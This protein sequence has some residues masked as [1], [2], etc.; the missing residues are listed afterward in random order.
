MMMLFLIF[1]VFFLFFYRQKR[2]LVTSAVLMFASGIL[3]LALI[4]CGMSFCPVSG[5][6]TAIKY[7][8]SGDSRHQNPSLI[9]YLDSQSEPLKYTAKK[10]K[11]RI[12]RQ[13]LKEG[14]FVVAIKERVFDNVWGLTVGH[15]EVL[16]FA[17]EKEAKH[18]YAS[19]L[20]LYGTFLY[21][22]ANF[23]REAMSRLRRLK[24]SATGRGN[25]KKQ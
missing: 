24:W 3:F 19:F 18:H 1:S 20:A 14:D 17:R 4:S 6:V 23:G 12:I 5:V 15:D 21:V 22:I 16:S 7:D 9:V 13:R 8:T 2:F 25:L 10:K 11:V